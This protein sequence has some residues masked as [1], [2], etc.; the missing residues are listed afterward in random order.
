MGEGPVRDGVQADGGG[1]VAHI[2]GSTPGHG[3]VF[4]PVKP[5]LLRGLIRSMPT[6]N[7]TLSLSNQYLAG[8]SRRILT[9]E[10]NRRRVKEGGMA[11]ATPDTRIPPQAPR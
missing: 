7:I 10:L 11:G 5:L 2:P 6:A 8:H 1:V 3:V 9:E 4:V